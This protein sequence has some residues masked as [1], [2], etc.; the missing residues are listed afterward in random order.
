M[1]ELAYIH[2]L[3]NRKEWNKLE[4]EAADLNVSLQSIVSKGRDLVD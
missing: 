3:M 2:H 1:R 4:A